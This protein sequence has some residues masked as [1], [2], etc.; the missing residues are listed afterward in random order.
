MISGK[1]ATA[2][3]RPSPEPGEVGSPRRQIGLHLD[4]A[5]LEVVVNKDLN[6]YRPHKR[7]SLGQRVL[8]NGLFQLANQCLLKSLKALGV[9]RSEPHAN[10][11]GGKGPDPTAV[12]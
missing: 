5:G 2:N 12:E 1:S 4:R 3:D 8:A 9:G 6:L 11:V 7:V 10:D